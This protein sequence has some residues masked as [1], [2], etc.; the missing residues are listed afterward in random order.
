[1][2]KIKPERAYAAEH[3]EAFRGLGE[4]HLR[5]KRYAS[6]ISNFRITPNGTLKKRGGY[7]KQESFPEPIRAYWKGYLGTK[8]YQFAACESKVFSIDE[9]T[10]DPIPMGNLPYPDSKVDFFEL[11]G[12]LFLL[13]GK[14]LRIFSIATQ[15][16]ES[17]EPYVPL[18]GKNWDPAIGGMAYEQFNLLTNRIRV[19]Y[20][21]ASNATTFK[22]PF[23]ARRVDSVRVN[24]AAVQ[25]YTWQTHSNLLTLP[26]SSTGYYVEV[27]ME[28]V[29]TDLGAD[30]RTAKSAEILP[31]QSHSTLLFYNTQNSTRIY[32]SAPVSTHNLYSCRV[33]YPNA[34]PIYFTEDDQINVG[35]PEHPLMEL[36]RFRD[37]LL[38]Y[39][40]LGTWMLTPNEDGRITSEPLLFNLACTAPKAAIVVGE[41]PLLINK[42]GIFLLSFSDFSSPPETE[43][44]SD[45]ISEL[46]GPHFWKNACAW[47]N[48]YF[49]EIWFRDTSDYSSPLLVY[50][51]R[52]KE[53]Y[54][55]E[56]IFA[57]D[58]LDTVEGS[59]FLVANTVYRI[60]DTLP[61]DNEDEIIAYYQSGY[62]SFGH[63]EARKRSLRMVVSAALAGD[64]NYIILETE[65]G[66]QTFQLTGSSS[67]VPD[68]FDLRV[69]LGRFRFLRFR[70]LMGGEETGKLHSLS[71]YANL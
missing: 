16:F 70:L 14:E 40:E 8:I 71:F 57:T 64:D 34:K 6:S 9:D 26:A 2:S 4:D 46:I 35:N 56:N 13:D 43:K 1:M 33:F 52:Q 63:P 41:T 49:E 42:N 38:A 28:A 20:E 29:M 65:N 69:L 31:N 55:F 61:T 67:T 27:A 17:I 66:Q 19:Q 25:G 12:E 3:F 59:L 36:C 21:N 24:G 7:V 32:P 22:L 68:C 47:N 10:G 51:Y 53:W 54:R 39:S 62:F 44:I 15:S 45:A 30:I 58:F 50:N 37:R 60:D 48:R 11:D 5:S 23:S 18:Y